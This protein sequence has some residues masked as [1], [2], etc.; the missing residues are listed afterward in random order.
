MKTRCHNPHVKA[1]SDYGGR[2]IKICDE[3]NDFK[4]FKNWALQNGYK[5]GL[6]IE[7]LDVDKGYTPNNC[8]WIERKAQSWNRR[9]TRYISYKGGIKI[10][11]RMEDNLRGKTLCLI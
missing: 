1:Y 10:C 8:I 2:G 11:W 9:N 3:W 5:E 6:T 7:R 4:A